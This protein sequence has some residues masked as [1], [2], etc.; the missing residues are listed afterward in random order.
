MI[1]D[2]LRNNAE[3]YFAK[4]AL[5]EAEYVQ[6]QYTEKCISW[7]DFYGQSN[8]VA[9]YL[10]DMG[11]KKGDKVGIYLQNCIEWLPI[12]FGILQT[13]AIVVPLNYRYDATELKYCLGV[14]ECLVLFSDLKYKDVLEEC[15]KGMKKV[16]F[17]VLTGDDENCWESFAEKSEA[18][19]DLMKKASLEATGT[20]LDASDDAAIYFTSGTTGT[21][22][23]ILI[24]HSSLEAA[25]RLEQ[26][27]HGQK[28]DDV[29]MVIPPLY[30]T[31]AIMHWFGSLMVGG[32]AVLLKKVS[33]R[34]IL[35][36]VSREKVTI[37]WLLVPWAQ[38]ILASIECGDVNQK[39][40]ELSQ[41]RL[42]HMG[43][44]PIPPSLVQNWLKVFPNHQ[45]DT[46]YG[47]SEATGP[48]CIHLGVENVH[49]VGAIGKAGE[50]WSFAIFR[51][52]GTRTD[53]GECGELAV[54]GP[55]IMKEY[56]KDPTA[57]GESLR[58]GWLYTGDMAYEDEDGF[59]YIVDRKKDIIIVGGENVSAVQIENY[60]SRHPAV[61]DVAVIGIKNER[62]GEF[63]LAVIELKPESECSK[64]E[65]NKFLKDLPDYKRPRMIVFDKVLRNSTGKIDKV[66]LRKKYNK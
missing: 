46:N 36:T 8:K 17:C 58:N 35:E 56:Y 40:Y 44:Q 27:H 22:K 66:G 37:V 57:T 51:E 15:F 11:I 13:G 41:W 24:S 47:L 52:D 29:F 48:G 59:V 62:V 6:N 30:H 3:K 5:K 53:T 14:T 63:I 7:G 34:Y 60:I 50:G 2:Y 64:S 32:K 54:S 23:A 16:P 45:Y 20:Q 49:K 25:A 61:K 31:G 28:S 55:G 65:M 18:F 39:E 9:N 26:K 19:A 21:P 33:P 10:I 43:A 1:F 12:F 38:D 4:D 42:M